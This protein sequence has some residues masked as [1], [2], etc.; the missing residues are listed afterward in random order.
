MAENN[1]IVIVPVYNAKKYIYRCLESIL[2]QTYKNYE[3]IVIDDCSTDNTYEIIKIVHAKFGNFTIHRHEYRVGV[4]LVA[5]IEGLK[6]ISKK[7]EEYVIINIDGDDYL[8][9]TNVFS[10]LNMVYQDENIWLTYGQY[11]PESHLYHNYCQPLENTRTYRKSGVWITSHIRTYRKK[12]FDL[13]KDED[14]RDKN[15]NYYKIGD[16]AVMFPL[17]EMCG[18]KRIKFISKV[19]YI[20]NDLNILC[21]MKIDSARQTAEAKEIRNKLEYEELPMEES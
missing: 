14:L 19:L 12:V 13:I 20:Y 5:R 18:L 3:L 16:A 21:T 4:S 8:S 10:Y 15:G 9:N 11:E 7:D 1:F 2:T 17:I 6:F